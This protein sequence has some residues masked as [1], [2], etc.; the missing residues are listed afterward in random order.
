MIIKKIFNCFGQLYLVRRILWRRPSFGIYFHV[1][2]R[3]DED[4]SLHCHPWPWGSFILFPGY[5]EWLPESWIQDPKDPSRQLAVGQKRHLRLPF[6]FS[7]KRPATCTHRVELFKIFGKEIP[8]LTFFFVGRR[9]REWGYHQK[10]GWIQHNDWW[11]GN[12]CD[13]NFPLTHEAHGGKST[14]MK[15]T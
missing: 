14:A 9:A 15:E 8:A 6:T 10:D 2:H 7:G 5:W 11:N 4:R 13:D 1:F 3:S 12:N